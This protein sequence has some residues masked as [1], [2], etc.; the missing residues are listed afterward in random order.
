MDRLITL[1]AAGAAL[2]ILAIVLL[3]GPVVAAFIVAGSSFVLMIGMIALSGVHAIE[4]WR[5]TRVH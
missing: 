4:R 2:T 1:A 3:Y 5:R